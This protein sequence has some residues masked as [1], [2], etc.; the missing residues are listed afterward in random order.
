MHVDRFGALDAVRLNVS[1]GGQNASFAEVD[2]ASRTLLDF[3]L[4]VGAPVSLAA[5]LAK[6]RLADRAEVHRAVTVASAEAR[7][8]AA[9]LVAAPFLLLPLTGRV[10]DMP[11]LTFYMSTVGRVVLLVAAGLYLAGFGMVWLFVRRLDGPVLAD[12]KN[13]HGWVFLPVVVAGFVAGWWVAVVVGAGALWFLSRRLADSCAVEDL[14][15]AADVLVVAVSAGMPLP[16]ALRHA[17]D[18]V[19]GVATPLRT[20]AYSLDVGVEPQE[21]GMFSVFAAQLWQA[22]TAGAPTVRLLEQFAVQLRADERAARLARTARL[23]SQLTIPTTV[24]FLP[25]TVLV[26]LAPVVAY[27][28]T[29]FM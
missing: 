14:S 18:L 17:A 28:V 29:T 7:T 21:E 3:A 10:L 1:S 13:G 16:A 23:P 24:L 19:A 2:G 27:G 5:E 22:H 20:I 11:V 8:V 9:F 25:A 15:F 12:E 26:M 4:R 6:R